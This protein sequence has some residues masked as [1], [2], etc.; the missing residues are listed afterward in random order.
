MAHMAMGDWQTAAA[1]LSQGLHL[2]PSNAQMVRHW[3][4]TLGQAAC[5]ADYH[6]RRSMFLQDCGLQC[7][8]LHADMC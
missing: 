7:S 8:I 3:L 6:A 5:L 4:A 1:A 2:D